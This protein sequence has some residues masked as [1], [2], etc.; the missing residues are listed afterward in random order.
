[1]PE[2]GDVVAG[3]TIESAWGNQ[4]RDRS[5]LR[6]ANAAARDASEIAPLEGRV[7]YLEDVDAL[8][9]YAAGASGPSRRGSFAAQQCSQNTRIS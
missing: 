8:Y 3:N 9:V 6:Y 2:I 1:M 4:I 7:C 5:T